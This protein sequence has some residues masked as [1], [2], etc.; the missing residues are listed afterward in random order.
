M[1]ENSWVLVVCCIFQNRAYP[2]KYY[3]KWTMDKY[4]INYFF[5]VTGFHLRL[6]NDFIKIH[7]F[8]KKN[9]WLNLHYLIIYEYFLKISQESNQR[10]LNTTLVFDFT[11][12]F[13]FCPLPCYFMKLPDMTL[14]SQKSHI[15]I[16]SYLH[17]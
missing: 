16:M 17:A 9:D 5:S 14:A 7:W 4:S 15:P 6:I 10:S 3:N 12:F 8:W 1:R 11:Y 13:W 2:R